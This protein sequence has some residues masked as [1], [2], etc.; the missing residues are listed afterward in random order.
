MARSIGK[1]TISFGLVSI[2][3]KLYSSGDP[4]SRISFN[5]LS[6]KGNRLKQQY[7]DP[8]DGSIVPHAE[9]LKGYEYAKGQY[10]SFTRAEIKALQE[11]ASP[12]V[13]ILSFVP[14][15]IPLAHQ[16]KVYYLMP[17]KGAE[18]AYE[19]LR[20]TLLSSGR[21]GLT[22]H[23]S[24]GKQHIAAIRASDECLI[25]QH[26]LYVDEVKPFSEVGP[27]PAVKLLPQ[28]MQLARQLVDSISTDT[29]DLSFHA[30]EVKERLE[31]AIAAKI[32]GRDIPV[33]QASEGPDATQDLLSALQ[34]SLGK[35][36]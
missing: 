22:K 10:V 21:V 19:L 18:R 35:A 29:I 28:E 24:H 26:L 7:I 36:A 30:D 25:L 20:Q 23:S 6:P 15:R 9:Q 5:L 14:D 4:S 8:T 32:E 34:Q 1:V 11:P 2:P 31:A 16:E 3:T 27:L 33:Q 12:V 17:E 13:P